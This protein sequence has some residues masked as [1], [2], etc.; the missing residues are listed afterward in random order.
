MALL[1]LKDLFIAIL[2]QLQLPKNSSFIT[3]FGTKRTDLCCTYIYMYICLHKHLKKF[4]KIIKHI[5]KHRIWHCFVHCY[6]TSTLIAKKIAL[7]LLNSVR[8]NRPT[9]YIYIY[10]Y[11]N[12][13]IWISSTKIIKHIHINLEYGTIVS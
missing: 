10:T 4:F 5:Y 3:Q 7:L 8:K 9:L 6:I 2:L 12:V 11:T 13:K 1:F